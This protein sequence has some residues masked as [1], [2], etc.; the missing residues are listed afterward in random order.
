MP[1]QLR[2]EIQHFYSMYKQPEGKEV[3]IQG[4]DDSKAA[5]AAIEKARQAYQ[6][7]QP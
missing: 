7:A 5:A 3:D 4:W 6:E 2:T 1:P